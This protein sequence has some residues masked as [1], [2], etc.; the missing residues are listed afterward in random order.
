MVRALSGDEVED[1]PPYEFLVEEIAEIIELEVNMP[2]T[3][4]IPI[5]ETDAMPVDKRHNYLELSFYSQYDM[6]CKFNEA[7]EQ[8]RAVQSKVLRGKDETQY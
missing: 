2:E 8:T 5:E 6:D 3:A 7:L 1:M 4:G